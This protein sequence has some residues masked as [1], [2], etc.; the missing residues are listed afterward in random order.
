M[1]VRCLYADW[2]HSA[3]YG[4]QAL[5]GGHP[6]IEGVIFKLHDYD[7]PVTCERPETEEEVEDFLDEVYAFLNADDRPNGQT[8]RSLSV[9]DIVICNNKAYRVAVIGFHPVS[10]RVAAYTQACCCELDL[11]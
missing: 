1:I 8:E 7:I 4:V 6:N 5:T 11:K 3:E 9:G 10:G 2:E